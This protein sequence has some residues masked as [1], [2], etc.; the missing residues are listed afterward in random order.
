MVYALCYVPEDKIVEN[1]QSINQRIEKDLSQDTSENWGESDI[2]TYLALQEGRDHHFWST[3][4][5]TH[6]LG[7]GVPALGEGEATVCLQVVEQLDVL[8]VDG[9]SGGY[10]ESS[11]C[12]S[13]NLESYNRTMKLPSGNSPN[14][15]RVIHTVPGQPGGWIKVHHDQQCNWEWSHH[16][17]GL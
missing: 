4:P 1:Y 13:N 14:L 15:R 6:G 8:V 10:Q 16:E 5:M 7:E 11:I 2:R 12:T 17:P 3:T 9:D